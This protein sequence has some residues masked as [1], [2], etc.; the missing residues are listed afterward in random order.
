MPALLFAALAC[1]ADAG[2]PIEAAPPAANVTPAAAPAPQPDRCP[3]LVDLEVLFIGNSYLNLHD[4]PL[5]LSQMGEDAGIK[6]G[7]DKVTM[8]GEN[9][10][11]HLRRPKTAKLLQAREWDMVVLQSHSLDPLRN[12]EGFL[13]AGAE[14][15]VRVRK[16]GAEP[17]LFETWPRRAGHN[18]YN[19]F[20]PAGGNPEAMQLA[21]SGRYAELAEAEDMR[22]VPVGTAWTNVMQQYPEIDLFAKDGGHPSIAGAYLGACVVFSVLT[23]HSPVAGKDASRG[24]SEADAETLRAVAYKVVNPRCDPPA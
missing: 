12:P 10:E 9:F 21:V 7:V 8:G 24:V 13:S 14:L 3:E 23:Q 17:L 2:R 5:R 18:V 4:L 20:K 16:Q 22:V 15:G 19:Y 6:I 1:H 11:Y